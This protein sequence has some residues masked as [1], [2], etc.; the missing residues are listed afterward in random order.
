ML[1][2]TYGKESN[3]KNIKQQINLFNKQLSQTK[4]QIRLHNQTLFDYAQILTQ[5][6]QYLYKTQIIEH[7]ITALLL[8]RKA[9]RCMG[10]LYKNNPEKYENLYANIL[11]QWFDFMNLNEDYEEGI[12]LSQNAIF[13]YQ[14][15]IKKHPQQ[16]LPTYARV[17]ATY[18]Y[19][20]WKNEQTCNAKQILIESLTIY[21]QL[22]KTHSRLLLDYCNAQ[23]LYAQCLKEDDSK[24]ALQT[25]KAC[26][27]MLE[28]IE[29]QKNTNFKEQLIKII[30]LY[31]TLLD[32]GR[33]ALRFSTKVSKLYQKLIELN[34]QL[35]ARDYA[36]FLV[37][38][39]ERCKNIVYNENSY[40]NTNNPKLKLAA[41]LLIKSII[42]RE[43]LIQNGALYEDWRYLYTLKSCSEI[44]IEINHYE[45]AVKYAKK[46]MDFANLSFNKKNKFIDLT[47]MDELNYARCCQLYALALSK[48]GQYPKAIKIALKGLFWYKQITLTDPF[49]LE[50]LNCGLYQERDYTN[51]L[52]NIASY[53]ETVGDLQASLN[54]I[55][56][57]FQLAKHRYLNVKENYNLRRYLEIANDYIN[58]LNFNGYQQQALTYSNQILKLAVKHYQ[59]AE[60]QGVYPP[61]L[62]HAYANNSHILANHQRWKKS[63]S[64]IQKALEIHKL[65]WYE[66]N[67]DFEQNEAWLLNLLGCCQ[68]QLGYTEKGLT[69]IKKSLASYLKLFSKN[70]S[71][72][73]VKIQN[74]YRNYA[75]YLKEQ[76]N[77][78]LALKQMQQITQ[79]NS[80]HKVINS[81]LDK[82]EIKWLNWLNG[83]KVTPN[84]AIDYE[85]SSLNNREKQKVNFIQY[86]QLTC[87][88]Q[89][90]DYLVRSLYY[91]DKMDKDLQANY[92]GE[93]TVLM[94]LQKQ[95]CWELP[96]DLPINHNWLN[97]YR[98]YIKDR[99]G[100]VPLW[101]SMTTEILDCSL[102]EIH[103]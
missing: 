13:F 31:I 82:L 37:S 21:K 98:Q 90:H 46:T 71:F 24:H 23:Y 76:G 7:E 84:K 69:N 58:L 102:P 32:N 40:N 91:F 52:Q 62:V 49:Y 61:F 9:I 68:N 96:E 15:L 5:H 103:Y 39:A 63:L 92:L 14:T 89:N 36:N 18:G 42:L 80:Q 79:L 67:N 10:W 60:F 53:L 12:R 16:Y 30:K 44:F 6:A 101:L 51:A 88:T 27:K 54:Y 85:N 59:I 43:K 74:V 55:K 78:Q 87:F 57:A 56:K 17:L 86:W 73:L 47:S 75:L 26:L 33:T 22:I 100:F 19:C 29:D 93:L 70:P 38:Y 81:P 64:Q 50:D 1:S 66:N 83:K 72:F 94:T 25:I 4:K 45:Q 8:A 48:Q 65:A 97:D 20:L 41:K 95:Q 2:I 77:F 11:V 35:Y 28:K 99:T 3:M 34:F